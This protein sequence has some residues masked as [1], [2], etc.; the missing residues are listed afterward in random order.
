MSSQDRVRPV[1]IA[2]GV[3]IGVSTSGISY[4]LVGPSGGLFGPPA[5]VLLC[6][7]RAPLQPSVLGKISGPENWGTAVESEADKLT[8]LKLALLED[9]LQDDA[10]HPDH[11]RAVQE[12]LSKITDAGY[13]GVTVLTEY[14]KRMWA[15]AKDQLLRNIEDDCANMVPGSLKIGF[16]FGIPAVWEEQTAGRMEQAI[17]RS[18]MTGGAYFTDLVFE[19]EAAALAVL[20][21]FVQ[22][23]L[24]QKDETVVIADLGG[25]TMDFISYTVSSDTPLEVNECVSGKGRLL[26]DMFMKSALQS[27]IKAEAEARLGVDIANFNQHRFQAQVD[28]VWTN[29]TLLQGG[30]LDLADWSI[31][32][33]AERQ[34]GA[35]M[36][37]FH[38]HGID[39]VETFRSIT[40]GI[41]ELAQSQ[42]ANLMVVVGG[43]GRNKFLQVELRNH[44]GND[45]VFF[46]EG[47]GQLA[48]KHGAALHGV[49]KFAREIA[50]SQTVASQS[51]ASQGT[52][53][54]EEPTRVTSRIARQSYGAW[55]GTGP[56]DLVQ[57]FI[58]KFSMTIWR[59][60]LAPPIV[61]PRAAF[62]AKIDRDLPCVPILKCGRK[63]KR[64]QS[65]DGMKTRNPCQ[66]RCKRP[67]LL[68]QIEEL[69]LKPRLNA[70]QQVEFD[71]PQDLT[72]IFEVERLG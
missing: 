57:W 30:A 50:A 20:P 60:T 31:E 18:G 66:I 64:I 47:G 33:L 39:I 59:P 23:H 71:V 68:Y 14:M 10:Q 51:V 38:V 32:V 40:N 70:R 44:F 7:E 63:T 49:T 17:A 54:G 19:P 21:Y 9:E 37:S 52:A 61:L 41:V 34:D 36:A 12:E 5:S 48:V 13:N 65:I 35:V 72:A 16:V 27:L 3:D 4:C 67:D 29:A 42:V 58:N 1:A 15:V 8:L 53:S 22:K 2:I 69:Q 46:T 25:G 45:F 43:F 55:M 11:L 28:K 62:Q 6:N 24:L 56:K 26:G